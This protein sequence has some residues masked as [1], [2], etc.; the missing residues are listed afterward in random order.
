[1]WRLDGASKGEFETDLL[2]N[3]YIGI[4]K[5]QVKARTAAVTE[6]TF[7]GPNSR[8]WSTMFQV[9]PDDTW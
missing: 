6:N 1:M 5:R 8:S 3:M 2:P 9:R 7:C 4:V